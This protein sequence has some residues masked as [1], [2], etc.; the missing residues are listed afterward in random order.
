MSTFIAWAPL[1]IIIGAVLF[2]G[3]VYIQ[4]LYKL[5]SL[6]LF[7]NVEWTDGTTTRMEVQ[8]YLEAQQLMNRLTFTWVKDANITSGSFIVGELNKLGTFTWLE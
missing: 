5:E 7:L 3:W 2:A 8:T 4:H 6:R 1:A